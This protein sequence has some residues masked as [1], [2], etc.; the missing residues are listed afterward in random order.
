MSKK[1]P[2]PP[3]KRGAPAVPRYSYENN[4]KVLALLI[5]MDEATCR[6]QVDTFVSAGLIGKA[7]TVPV[8]ERKLR[9]AFKTPAPARGHLPEDDHL[10]ALLLYIGT[11]NKREDRDFS[12]LI[13]IAD[14]S[15]DMEQVTQALVDH[16]CDKRSGADADAVKAIF[17]DEHSTVP[18][19]VAQDL[20]YTLISDSVLVGAAM[21]YR[22]L[23]SGVRR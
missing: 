18:A 9:A 11:W 20:S 8:M 17:A 7:D 12:A 15:L 14:P 3:K 2:R 13:D 23:N 10:N 4:V 1:S 22:L 21:M 5:G 6:H 19:E 16:A